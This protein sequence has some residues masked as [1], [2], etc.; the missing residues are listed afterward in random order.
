MVVCYL[1]TEVGG[2]GDAAEA[3]E[4]TVRWRTTEVR[5][6]ELATEGH[7]LLRSLDTNAKMI[8]LL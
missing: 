3:G 7:K 8:Y 1:G 2:F 6:Q 5:P 4:A